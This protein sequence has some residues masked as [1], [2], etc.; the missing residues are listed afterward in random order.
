MQAAGQQA[1]QSS[2]SE[3]KLPRAGI[4]LAL[5]PVDA[6]KR[7]LSATFLLGPAETVHVN[8][9]RQQ[10][11]GISIWSHASCDGVVGATRLVNEITLQGRRMQNQPEWRDYRPA[12]RAA[13]PALAM[14]TPE[15]EQKTPKVP[16]AMVNPR[17]V[18][19]VPRSRCIVI[20]L[21]RR[22]TP[23]MPPI[24]ISRV[25]RFLPTAHRAG[26]ESSRDGSGTCNALIALR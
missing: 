3:V 7:P 14:M 15:V 13:I 8:R 19:P 9:V 5:T 6:G 4:R 18:L 17:L 24:R 23:T 10:H 16:E 1:G 12:D 20:V 22:L 2:P 11:R 25:I 26:G 21:R